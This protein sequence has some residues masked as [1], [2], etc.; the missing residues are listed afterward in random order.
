MFADPPPLD[1]T[2]RLWYNIHTPS[3]WGC[4]RENRKKDI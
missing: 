1:R 4:P 3:P 2:A